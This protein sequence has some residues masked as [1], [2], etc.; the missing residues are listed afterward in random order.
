[1][2]EPIFALTANV[3]EAHQQV[4]VNPSD[5]HLFG[6]KLWLAPTS[7][8]TRWG[9]R[10]SIGILLL[11]SHRSIDWHVVVLELPREP[12][13]CWAQTTATLIPEAS[14]IDMCLWSSLYCALMEFEGSWLDDVRSRAL[15]NKRPLYKFLQLELFNGA[16]SHK[17]WTLKQ[18]RHGLGLEVGSLQ[19][20][21]TA[22]LTSG[23]HIGTHWK[24]ELTSV[25]FTPE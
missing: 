6:A 22:R 5:R 23:T 21:K 4:P 13:T 14:L 19:R 17:L 10:S 7:S 16:G 11:V 2:D 9:R 8:S 3:S 1:M 24:Y 20:T 18:Y 12:G 25:D 15:E